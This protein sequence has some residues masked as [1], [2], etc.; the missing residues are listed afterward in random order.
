MPP[1]SALVTNV[2]FARSSRV[3]VIAVTAEKPFRDLNVLFAK[4]M[5]G[6]ATNREFQPKA[7][8]RK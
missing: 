1:F 8:F 5:F 4:R 2:T 6:D 7:V 3:G